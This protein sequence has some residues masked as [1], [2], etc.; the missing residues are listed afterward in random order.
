MRDGLL[1]SIIKWSEKS[2]I[3]HALIQTGSLARADGTADDLSDVDIEI[4]TSKPSS[5]GVDD[6]WLH[7]IGDLITV[8]RLNPED[9]QEWATRLAIYSEGVKV[10]FMLAGI[11]R[12]RSMIDARM[13]DPLYERGYRVLLDKS[14]ATTGLPVPSYGFPAAVLPS[15]EEFCAIVEEFWFEAFHVPKYLARGELWLVK[16]RDW[17][18][19]EL[20]LRMMEWHAVTR[21]IGPIDVWHIG[22]RMHEWIGRE[23]RAELQ[24]IFGRFEAADARRAFEAT[25]KLFGRLGREV[26]Q[27]TDL[28][29]PQR[30]ENQ[31]TA[32]NERL[33][34]QKP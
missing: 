26:A 15:Q 19:K 13:L 3:V 25:T 27:T 31:I 7:Q 30:V 18:M 1:T 8:L 14:G 17:T 21:S 24:G 11:E 23:T 22:T 32:L 16:Q 33:L 29:Y 28:E 12:V 5:L 34:S 10:D 9:G 4:I 20:L 6:S 2:D